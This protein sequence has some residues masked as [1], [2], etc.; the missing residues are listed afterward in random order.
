[1]YK[2]LKYLVIVALLLCSNITWAQKSVRLNQNWEFLKQDLGGIW[3]AVRPVGVGNPES[4][5]LW[6]KVNLP[7]CVNAT[8]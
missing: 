7:H 2:Y 8:D 4:V 6:Q 1:M 5:P 3:E